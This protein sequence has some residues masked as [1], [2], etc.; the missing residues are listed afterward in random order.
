M[1]LVEQPYKHYLKENFFEPATFELLKEVSSSSDWSLFED[2]NFPQYI[3]ERKQVED[4]FILNQNTKQYFSFLLDNGFIKQLESL[5][6]T[7]LK[8]CVSISFHKLTQGCFNVVH[9]DHNSNGEKL[10]VVCYLSNPT[11]YEGGELN[12]FSLTNQDTP[13]ISYKLKA[14]TAFIFSMTEN[15][16]HSVSEVVSGERVCLVIT[17]Q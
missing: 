8:E 5:F 1:K 3:S 12:L 17:Y 11:S 13:F 2:K 16:V 9:N 10:R 14:N 7:P 15:S 6:P 4:F